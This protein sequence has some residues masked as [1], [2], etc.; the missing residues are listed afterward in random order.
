MTLLN[1]TF[2]V[3]LQA[4]AARGAGKPVAERTVP[5]SAEWLSKVNR[6]GELFRQIG[7]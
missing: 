1:A 4:R 6:D 5:G 7:I 3:S 2:V